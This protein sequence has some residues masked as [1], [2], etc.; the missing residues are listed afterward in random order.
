[1]HGSNV[2]S[3]LVQTPHRVR[4]IW[5]LVAQAQSN[6]VI[7]QNSR[8]HQESVTIISSLITSQCRR[9]HCYGTTP[10]HRYWCSIDATFTGGDPD[11]RTGDGSDNYYWEIKIMLSRPNSSTEDLLMACVF[12]KSYA[13]SGTLIVSLVTERFEHYV[14]L[15]DVS[16]LPKVL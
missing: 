3:N 2:R 9:R 4:L 7:L 6:G 8:L 12:G 11:S 1:M 15:S 14:N 16:F 5:T 10:H 13:E